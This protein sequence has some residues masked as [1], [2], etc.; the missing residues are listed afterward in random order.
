MP[1]TA[2][3]NPDRILKD[4]QAKVSKRKLLERILLLIFV[5][6]CIVAT[7]LYS[8]VFE[9]TKAMLSPKEQIYG[10]WVEENVADYAAR[11][12]EVSPK[13]ISMG[14]RVYTTQFEFDGINLEFQIAGQD[15]KYKV[16]NREKT[17]LKLVT[18][19]YYKPVFHLSE[20]N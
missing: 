2:N 1:K 8:N 18:D 20:K 11:K 4:P 10:V 15:Y 7:F 3:R 6:G 16:I 12:I 17:E 5:V 13:G 14:G 9:R 19:S